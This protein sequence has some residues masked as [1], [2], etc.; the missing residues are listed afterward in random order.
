MP[1]KPVRHNSL[2]AT[3]V[4]QYA[5]FRGAASDCAHRDDLL[6][7]RVLMR[8]SRSL[9]TAVLVAVVAAACS[10]KKTEGDPAAAA[11]STPVAAKPSESKPAE[12]R[13][14]PSGREYQIGWSV[15]TGYM[16]FKLMETKGFLARRAA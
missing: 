16:P 6:C 4:L 10:G 15:W 13:P 8:D 14:T 1:K 12:A 9:L 2:F 7:T 5:A 11:G 3:P